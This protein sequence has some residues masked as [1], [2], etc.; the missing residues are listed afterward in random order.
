MVV[1]DKT[2]MT[3]SEIKLSV[4]IQCR[5]NLRGVSV[6]HLLLQVRDPCIGHK[7]FCTSSPLDELGNLE[8]EFLHLMG[9]HVY[10][11]YNYRWD[12][13]WPVETDWGI[14]IVSRLALSF[15]PVYYR[16]WMRVEYFNKY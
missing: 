13:N 12:Q 2:T 9:K 11:Y 3:S 1:L 8:A 14:P 7:K 6:H 5:C 15:P 16:Q 4:P 10:D